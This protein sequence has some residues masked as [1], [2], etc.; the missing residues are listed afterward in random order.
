MATMCRRRRDRSGRF[1]HQEAEKAKGEGVY[2]LFVSGLA[3]GTRY[4][5]RADGGAPFASVQL[6]YRVLD[7]GPSSGVYVGAY[8]ASYFSSSLSG[9]LTPALAIGFH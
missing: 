3:A 4:G 5:I 2:A 7:V 6:G 8:L 1:F 9:N